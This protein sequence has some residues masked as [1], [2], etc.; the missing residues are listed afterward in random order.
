MSEESNQEE[1][2]ERLVNQTA[3]WKEVGDFQA[4]L[5]QP[6]EDGAAQRERRQFHMIATAMAAGLTHAVALLR[7]LMHAYPKSNR[8]WLK[9]RLDGLGEGRQEG[10]T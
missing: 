5:A 1:R 7:P 2:I 3:L 6:V 10:S 9:R 4:A 8:E